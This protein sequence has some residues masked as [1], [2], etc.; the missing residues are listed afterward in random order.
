MSLRAPVQAK[1]TRRFS[2]G[3]WRVLV[4]TPGLVV[5]YGLAVCGLVAGLLTRR[6]RLQTLLVAP[7]LALPVTAAGGLNASES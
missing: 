4:G 5:G 2:A 3:A 6:A 1:H 7:L